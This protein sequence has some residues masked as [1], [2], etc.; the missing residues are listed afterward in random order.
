MS[1]TLILAMLQTGFGVVSSQ[2]FYFEGIA[3]KQLGAK[4]RL[5]EECSSCSSNIRALLT[6]KSKSP[7]K[8]N[9]LNDTAYH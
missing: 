9:K 8:T 1:I 2:G 3:G 4:R 5:N 7:L 6:I